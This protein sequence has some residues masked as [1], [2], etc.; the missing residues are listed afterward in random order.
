MS[1]NK[2]KLLL[3]LI[4]PYLHL[5]IPVTILS[6][7]VGILSGISIAA[8]FPLL[9]T[10]LNINQLQEQGRILSL[11][12]NIVNLI[13][14]DDKVIAASFFM[15]LAIMLKNAASVFLEFLTGYSGAKV[16]YDMKNRIFERYASAPYQ[17]FLDNKQGELIYNVH[18]AP[19]KVRDLLILLPKLTTKSFNIICFTIILLSISVKMTLLIFVFVLIFYGI[20]NLLSK[21]VSYP[22]GKEKRENLVLK[23][24]ITNEF[25]NGVKQI[26]V[27]CAKKKWLAHFNALNE[28]YRKLYV[29]SSTLLVVPENAL[30]LF[31]FSTAAAMALILKENYPHGFVSQIPTFGIYVVALQRLLPNVSQFSKLHMIIMDA[32]PNAQ[33]CFNTLNDTTEAS[34]VQKDNLKEFKSLYR[35]IDFKDVSFFYMG[36]DNLLRNINVTIEKGK[37]TA[38]VGPSGVGKT[39]IINLVLGLFSPSTGSVEL[40]GVDLR[41]YKIE[42]WLEKIGFVSQDTFIFHSTIADNIS[43]GSEKYSM[44]N[45]I[46]AATIAHVHDFV[47]SFPE[48]YNTIVGERGMKLSGGQQQRIALAR[49]ILRKPEILILD[50]ATSSLDNI[51]ESQV[52]EAIGNISEN[53]T[54]IVVAHRLSTVKNADK[55]VMLDNGKIAEEGTHSELLNRK[56]YYWNLY[57]RQGLSHER[58]A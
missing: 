26:A 41:D 3:Y 17:F 53:L 10:L 56:G 9:N 25:L 32:L 43:F 46:N 19:E 8:L 24:V 27:F 16:V 44:K 11:M 50:E 45:I 55:I 40:D 23:Q 7:M 38:I 1:N 35:S 4:K 54:V 15:I 14:F 29:K 48:G 20:T 28:R 30:E 57:K 47:Q 13:P 2:Y 49:A 33:I 31:M 36:R 21:R 6:L 22:I 58:E 18:T 51:S 42:T 34:N 52:Q 37:L 39:T 5:Y 12:Q